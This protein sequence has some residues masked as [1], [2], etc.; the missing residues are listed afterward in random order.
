M[1]RYRVYLHNGKFAGMCELND[2]LIRQIGAYPTGKT[3]K[4]VRLVPPYPT[5]TLKVAE[6]FDEWCLG[7]FIDGQ[8]EDVKVFKHAHEAY[9]AQSEMIRAKHNL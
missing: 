2:E 3:G 8:L 9:L 7:V 5:M 4:A 6:G 1:K